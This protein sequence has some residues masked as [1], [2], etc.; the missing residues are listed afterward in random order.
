MP[1]RTDANPVARKFGKAVRVARERRK[2]TLEEVARRIPTMDAKYLG[3]IER[4]WHEPRIGTAKRIAEALELRLAD[5]VRE[6]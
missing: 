6:L 2:E 4:G 3:E 1:R 5:L